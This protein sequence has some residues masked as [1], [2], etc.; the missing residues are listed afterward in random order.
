MSLFYCC[1]G[2]RL[3]VCGTGLLTVPPTIHLLDG[4]C[5][6]MEEWWND[7]DRRKQNDSDKN[8][9]QCHLSPHMAHGLSWKQTQAST[10]RRRQLAAYAMT[11]PVLWSYVVL[12]VVTII[13][14][15]CVA[16]IFR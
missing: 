3:Y 12:Y 7:T 8:V 14:M 15:E 10:V 5:V 16:S 2:M 9:S 11:C 1:I 13:L 6:K 4:K